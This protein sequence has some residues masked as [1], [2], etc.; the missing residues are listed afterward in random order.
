MFTQHLEYGR[1][2]GGTSIFPPSLTA[3][4][5]P[6]ENQMIGEAR[7]V[8]DLESTRNLNPFGFHIEDWVKANPE[9]KFLEATHCHRTP[10]PVL[11][12]IIEENWPWGNLNAYYPI[13]F[14]HSTTTYPTVPFPDER[15]SEDET[16]EWEGMV[17]EI[18]GD[19]FECRIVLIKGSDANFEEFIT[20]P[21]D[22]VPESDRELIV[23]GAIFRLVMGERTNYGKK[24]YYSHVIFKEPTPLDPA[25]VE[26]RLA[27]LKKII[28]DIE[29]DDEDEA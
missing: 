20:I 24:E 7:D 23:P 6:N 21:I 25:E 4:V 18:S 8:H 13:G 26:E 12:G 29:W 1:T 22:R 27:Y 16:A 3:S 28:D 11:Y 14:T 5:L 2:P 9:Q 17:E 15:T 19:E 10:I